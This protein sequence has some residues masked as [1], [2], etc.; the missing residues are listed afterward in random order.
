MPSDASNA[1]ASVSGLS[2][3]RASRSS[4]AEIARRYSLPVIDAAG[5]AASSGAH[6]ALL[7]LSPAFHAALR[8]VAPQ[9]RR[10]Q[11]RYVIGFAVLAVFG[12]LASD[13]STREFAMA[14]WGHENANANAVAA[15]PGAPVALTGADT[16][17]ASLLAASAV[18]SPAATKDSESESSVSLAVTTRSVSVGAE[19]AAAPSA[20]QPQQV[21][22][23]RVATKPLPR[24][25]V[26]PAP[27]PKKPSGRTALPSRR[28]NSART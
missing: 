14:K 7:T 8:K 12:A 9:K 20:A 15:A 18:S 2:V 28:T 5:A 10:S 27:A 22:L 1:P 4:V 26:V 19:A 3:K 13:R 25:A 6:T 11:I 16:S 23:P 17:V 21:V 24:K